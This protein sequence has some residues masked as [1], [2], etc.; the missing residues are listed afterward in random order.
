M[1]SS[2]P[3]SQGSR[4]IMG[5]AC[6]VFRQWTLCTIWRTWSLG[7]ISTMEGLFYLMASLDKR[8]DD[9][10]SY[11]TLIWGHDLEIKNISSPSEHHY[12]IFSQQHAL[13]SLRQTANENYSW[14]SPE[15]TVL[16]SVLPLGLWQSWPQISVCFII[17]SVTETDALIS[18]S[19]DGELI[20]NSSAV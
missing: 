10:W 17:Q 3:L 1:T 8:I 12:I 20:L 5:I 2:K 9:S 16:R 18:I 6:W 19:A 13:I 11:L 7:S 15:R 4:L 14:F